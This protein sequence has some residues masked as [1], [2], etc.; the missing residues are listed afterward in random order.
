MKYLTKTSSKYIR[1]LHHTVSLFCNVSLVSSLV[2][3]HPS[4]L[5]N[6]FGCDSFC[7]IFVS[8][9]AFFF[10]GFVFFFLAVLAVNLPLPC[11]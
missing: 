4:N 1:A 11:S 6:V 8:T 5:F 9:Q 2:L 7:N 10:L 3:C